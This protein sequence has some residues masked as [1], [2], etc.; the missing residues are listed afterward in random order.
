ML[1]LAALSMDGENS[2]IVRMGRELFSDPPQV[3][4]NLTS[5]VCDHRLRTWES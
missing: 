3:D 1:L 5:T 2:G 4:L